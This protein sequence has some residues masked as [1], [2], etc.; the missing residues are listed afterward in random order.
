MSD[1]PPKT[2]NP[3]TVWIPIILIALGSVVFYN[4]LVYVQVQKDGEHGERPPFIHRAEG[5]L[6]LTERDG[7][8]VRLSE[9]RGKIILASWVFTRCPRGCAGVVA[10]MKK[11]SEEYAGNPDVHFIAFALD[12]E[13]T[14]EMLKA[15]ADQVG[16]PRQAPWWFVNGDPLKVREFM[17]RQL[18]FRPVQ[19]MPEKDRL[20]PEDKY[21]HDL[22]V[23]LVDHLGN[24]RRLADLVNADPEV[25]TY[26]DKQLRADL[27]YVV[28]EKTKADKKAAP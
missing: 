16:I 3:W 19:M 21:I 18:K 12:P 2:I 27:D 7:R 17:T 1:S 24:V 9:L 4:Y 25:A 28:N 8:Q 5:D 11:L 26:W 23:A 14:P 10:K 22:R 15:F 20:S 13:D 6:I